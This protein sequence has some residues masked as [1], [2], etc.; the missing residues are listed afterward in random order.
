MPLPAGRSPGS[1]STPA[2]E[3]A[4]AEQHRA[5]QSDRGGVWQGLLASLPPERG[6]S[7]RGRQVDRPPL[8]RGDDGGQ[9]G[10]LFQS[11]SARGSTHLVVD[12]AKCQRCLADTT[13]PWGAIGA[14]Y[15]GL[16]MEQCG[17]ARWPVA[18]W[19]RHRGTLER[20]AFKTALHAAGARH[21]AR[22]RPGARPSGREARDH[23]ARRVRARVRRDTLGPGTGLAPIPL[24]APRARVRSGAPLDGRQGSRLTSRAWRSC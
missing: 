21:P 9:L 5:G 20:A 23:V 2:S 4:A 6:A 19:L 16:H 24:H 12:G 1:S 13:I 14:N 15:A 17:F 22:I 10:A 18:T 3:A 11:K 8:C 7:A